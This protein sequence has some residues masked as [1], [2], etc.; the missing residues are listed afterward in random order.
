MVNRA[1]LAA[2]LILWAMVAIACPEAKNEFMTSP[3]DQ[4]SDTAI[5]RSMA[6]VSLGCYPVDEPL[7]RAGSAA[8]VSGWQ[9]ASAWP[10]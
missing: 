8:P 2:E 9:S 3:N 7:P 6:E 5:L 4:K 1:V 10:S